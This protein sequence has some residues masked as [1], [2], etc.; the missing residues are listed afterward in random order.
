MPLPFCCG[1]LVN[2]CAPLLWQ[3]LK[4]G[5]AELTPSIQYTHFSLPNTPPTNNPLPRRVISYGSSI[6]GSSTCQPSNCH[7]ADAA[8][9]HPGI[10]Y[11]INALW[12]R[13]EN[14]GMPE[15]RRAIGSIF[16]RMR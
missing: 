8:K 10:D 3:V 16:S 12:E 2:I 5:G 1:W 15:L 7:T 6:G 4:V 14:F 9:L 13:L 11:F